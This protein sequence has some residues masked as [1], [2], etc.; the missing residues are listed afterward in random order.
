M[1]CNDRTRSNVIYSLESNSLTLKNPEYGDTEQIVKKKTVNDT[2]GLV[3][4]VFRRDIWPAYR[5]LVYEFKGMCEDRV[6][7][8]LDF[9]KQ[10]QG[11][12]IELLDYNDRIWKGVISNPDLKIRQD[13]ND[14]YHTTIEFEGYTELEVPNLDELVFLS[15]SPEWGD[16]RGQ[17][18]ETKIKYSI[19]GK[20]HTYNKSTDRKIYEYVFRNDYQV[21]RELIDFFWFYDDQVILINNKPCVIRELP[22][23]SYGTTTTESSITVEEL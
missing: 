11:L 2:R 18:L 1:N 19:S 5:K 22:T 21:T 17:I 13:H 16:T 4:K 20:R 12:E 9:V 10:T 15:R 23:F 14:N 3:A 7:P 8:I 6:Q